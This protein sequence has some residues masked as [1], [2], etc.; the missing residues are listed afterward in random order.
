MS[1]TTKLT[2]PVLALRGLVI[3][4]DMMIQFDISRRKSVLALAG[5]MESMENAGSIVPSVSGQV[6]K[7]LS[8]RIPRG[9]GR[10]SA[11]QRKGSA[12]HT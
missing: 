4:P 5:A 1:E 7:K 10:G 8:F 6:A 3:F 9:S 2:I 11:M 12:I